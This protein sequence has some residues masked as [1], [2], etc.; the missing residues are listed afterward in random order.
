MEDKKVVKISKEKL[1]KIDAKRRVL[2]VPEKKAVNAGL[3]VLDAD[4]LL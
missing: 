4:D 1:E 3:E 2:F